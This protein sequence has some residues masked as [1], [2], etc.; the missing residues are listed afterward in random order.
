MKKR[1][2]QSS[3]CPP[4]VPEKKPFYFFMIPFSIQSKKRRKTGGLD[5]IE[6]IVSIHF[7]LSHNQV[8]DWKLS[9]SVIVSTMKGLIAC[10]S[11]NATNVTIVV[12][13]EFFFLKFFQSC[14][15]CQILAPITFKISSESRTKK[16]SEKNVNFKLNLTC[17]LK[18]VRTSAYSSTVTQ[19]ATEL[20]SIRLVKCFKN[21]TETKNFQ[22]TFID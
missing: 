10:W 9:W 2:Y 13:Q 12:Q 20:L 14:Q 17:T 1:T 11:K 3:S 18:K 8:T 7:K 21:G 22:A 6:L 5:W 19:K 16:S 15:S 4:D